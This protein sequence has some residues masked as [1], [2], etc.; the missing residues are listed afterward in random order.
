M[1]FRHPVRQAVQT[2]I[3]LA[4][5]KS[6]NH[7]M[8]ESEIER[9]NSFEIFDLLGGQTDIQCFYVI[10]QVFNFPTTNNG[11]DIG[12]FLHHVCDGD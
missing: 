8:R 4:K 2:H 3:H 9:D 12:C 10:H 7:A 6:Y 1:S 11:E 5:K